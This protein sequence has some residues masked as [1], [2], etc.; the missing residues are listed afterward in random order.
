MAT[1]TI[2]CSHEALEVAR[3]HFQKGEDVPVH[4]HPGITIYMYVI[5][6]KLRIKSYN[7]VGEQ[8]GK[9]IFRQVV[10]NV[11]SAGESASL[12]PEHANVHSLTILEDDTQFIDAFA[13]PYA[14]NDIVNWYTLEAIPGQDGDFLATQVERESLGLCFNFEE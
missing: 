3:F 14:C 5:S 7:V 2:E 1:R 8:E 12:T 9:K 10:D 11:L 4:D 13:P 6:G